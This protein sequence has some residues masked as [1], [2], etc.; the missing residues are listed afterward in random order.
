[1]PLKLFK[2]VLT[3]TLT[4]ISV[5]TVTS[6]VSHADTVMRSKPDHTKPSEVMPYP[7][8]NHVDNLNILVKS[9]QLRTK[10]RSL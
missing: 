1:M 4:I 3:I 2:L 5:L 9:Q 10:V 8:L 7:D 6:S